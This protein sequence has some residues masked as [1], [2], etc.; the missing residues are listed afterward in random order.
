MALSARR[1]KNVMRILF[2]A[3]GGKCCYCGKETKR[4]TKARDQSKATIEHLRRKAEGGCNGNHNLAMAC[5]KCN[6]GRG[7]M[8]WLTYKSYVLGEL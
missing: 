3:Q 2:S 5:L 1:R 8:D 6:Q 4:N 7:S